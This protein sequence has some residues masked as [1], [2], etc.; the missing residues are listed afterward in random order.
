MVSYEEFSYWVRTLSSRVS[1]SVC[2]SKISLTLLRTS[3]FNCNIYLL[4]LHFLRSKKEAVFHCCIFDL[5]DRI[6]NILKRHSR[7]MNISPNIVF[8]YV[9][10]VNRHALVSC[11]QPSLEIIS[12]HLRLESIIFLLNGIYHL[13]FEWARLQL[14][15]K[16]WGSI[17]LED[18]CEYRILWHSWCQLLV[19]SLSKRCQFFHHGHYFFVFHNSE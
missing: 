3:C 10:M 9:T 18:I 6:F 19:N 5:F 17:L 8:S 1:I 2:I 7:A 16:V 14:F 12:N 11:M 13:Y 15:S 4:P